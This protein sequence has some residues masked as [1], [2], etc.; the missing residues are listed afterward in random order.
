MPPHTV[1]RIVTAALVVILFDGGMHIGWNRFRSQAK[2]VVWLGVAGTVATAG[3]LA[4]ICRFVLGLDWRESLLLGTALA[5][6]DPAVVFSVLGG[7]EI[8]GRTG[9]LLEG[10]SGANDPVGIAMM[11]ALL[12]SQSASGG[13][14]L[15][16][17]LIEFVVQMAVGAAIG[18][19]GGLGLRFLM[20]ASGCRAKAS[21]RCGRSPARSCSTASPR[22]RTAPDSS[23]C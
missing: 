20:A 12:G 2:A 21:T 15:A 10:E 22:S 1:E 7:Q 6:T 5:P 23:P 19:G 11:V 18:I 4:L 3:G 8:T 14:A 9:T 13:A 16:H 17:G